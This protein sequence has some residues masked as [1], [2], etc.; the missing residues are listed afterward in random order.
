V[1]ESDPTYKSQC[2]R[3]GHQH[4]YRWLFTWSRS[5]A[6]YWQW[7][8]SD[9]IIAGAFLWSP[10][11]AGFYWKWVTLPLSSIGWGDWRLGSATRRAYFNRSSQLSDWAGCGNLVSVAARCEC[12]KY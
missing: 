12:Q 10:W 9:A 11:F 5:S 3:L 1:S 7:L 8:S 2:S 6:D 4:L